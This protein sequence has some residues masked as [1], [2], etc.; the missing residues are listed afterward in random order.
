MGPWTSSLTV[1]LFSAM[2]LK[3]K[4]TQ[5]IGIKHPV[6]QG[7]M[8]YVGYA[9]MAAAVSNAGCLG[10]ITSLTV[11]QGPDAVENLRKEIKKCKALTDKPFAVNLTLL[12]VGV[13]PDWD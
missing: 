10:T 7:G 6:I 8:H 5:A 9:E 12:P 3:T 1:S 4:L 2:V 11:A 13:Q